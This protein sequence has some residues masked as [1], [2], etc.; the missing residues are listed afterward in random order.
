MINENL[1]LSGEVIT[2]QGNFDINRI[3]CILLTLAWLRLK[4]QFSYSASNRESDL[5]QQDR[6]QELELESVRFNKN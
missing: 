6:E 1:F 4:N 5:L 3:F 2:I